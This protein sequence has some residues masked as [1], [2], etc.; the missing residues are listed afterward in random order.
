MISFNTAFQTAI[1]VGPELQ[2]LVDVVQPFFLKLSV[3]VGGLFGIYFILIVARVWYERKKVKLLQD[4]RYNLDSYNR[5]QGISYSG[6]KK[7]FLT[8]FFNHLRKRKH[9][10]EMEDHFNKKEKTYKK[11]RRK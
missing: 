9:I 7:G 4:I 10:R 6:Q 2:P 1:D 5:S 3:V 8:L 11:K